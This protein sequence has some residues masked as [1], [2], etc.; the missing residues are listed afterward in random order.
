MKS[1]TKKSDQMKNNPFEY[2]IQL[3]YPD[4]DTQ[5]FVNHSKICTY[6][7][8]AYI[9]FF[10]DWV[11]TKWNYGHIPILLK[12]STT[13]FFKPITPASSPVCRVVIKDVRSKGVH[14]EVQIVD[15]INRS[16]IYVKAERILIHVDLINAKPIVFSKKILNCL[17]R[18][19]NNSDLK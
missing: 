13:E 14:I 6:V 12:T 15:N 11:K 16:I 19:C 18:L 7:E 5:L 1:L 2:K 3:R 4:F 17:K 9:S 8:S 10:V